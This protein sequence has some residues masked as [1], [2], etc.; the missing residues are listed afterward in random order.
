MSKRRIVEIAAFIIMA[1]A[2]LWLSAREA[3]R[4]V[5]VS[6]FSKLAA[7]EIQFQRA[8]DLSSF[9][10]YGRLLDTTIVSLSTLRDS[11]QERFFYKLSKEAGKKYDLNWKILYSVWMRESRMDPNAKGDGR[12]DSTGTFVPGTWKAFGLGQV[13]V[14]SAKIHYDQAITKERLLDPI[15]NGYASAAILKDY[16]TIFKD[17]VYGVASYQAGPATIDPDFKSKKAP[18]NWRYVSDVLVLAAEVHD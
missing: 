15:E 1:V 12:K 13:H 5:A 9:I 8:G 17:P 11:L 3:D 4:G 16:I 2:L 14:A 18:R 10:G 7:A 6:P